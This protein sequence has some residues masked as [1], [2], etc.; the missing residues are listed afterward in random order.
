[1]GRF[2]T[3]T[4][5]ATL[6][7]S[8]EREIFARCYSLLFSVYSEGYSFPAVL[9]CEIIPWLLAARPEWISA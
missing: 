7:P 1:M 6:V 5:S 3:G 9:V 4:G 8:H 2:V